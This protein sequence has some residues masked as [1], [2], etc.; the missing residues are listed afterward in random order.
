M[1]AEHVGK[2]RELT[3]ERT[4]EQRLSTSVLRVQLGTVLH[5]QP[6]HLVQTFH[7]GVKIEHERIPLL[8]A[9][10][11]QGWFVAEQGIDAL[12]AAGTNGIENRGERK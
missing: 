2:V 1:C 7:L 11:G 5:E 3:R 6:N 9:G 8:V 10:V 4:S 12:H